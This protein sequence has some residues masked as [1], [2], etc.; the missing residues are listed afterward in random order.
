MDHEGKYND[1]AKLLK[2]YLKGNPPKQYQYQPLMTLGNLAYQKRDDAGALQYYNEAV[3]ANGGNLKEIDAESIAMAA[4]AKGDKATA[5]KY[6]KL[7]IQLT[8]VQPGVANNID[9]FKA[10]IKYLGG[11]P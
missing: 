5:I 2:Q 3:A 1:E 8:D 10:T 9:D 6:Y 11:T 7:A 4:Q